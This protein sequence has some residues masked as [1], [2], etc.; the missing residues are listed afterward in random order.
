MKK[1]YFFIPFFF[2]ATGSVFAAV[3]SG[4]IAFK[5][6]IE[7]N[8]LTLTSKDAEIRLTTDCKASSK[9]YGDGTWTWSNGGFIINLKN[10]KLAF[11]R[12]EVPLTDIDKCM[13]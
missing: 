10:K 9:K 13:D 5:E 3:A 6:K 8:S 1:V 11:G 7:N 4:G 12:Q 2:A